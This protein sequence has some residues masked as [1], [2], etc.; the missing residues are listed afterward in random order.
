MTE[1]SVVERLQERRL[2]LLPLASRQRITERS[3][4]E[5]L[6]GV[7]AALLVFLI[8]YS[9][10]AWRLES[11]P[12]LFSDEILYTRAGIRVATAGALIWDDGDPLFVH[13]PLYFL[14]EAA[15]LR[16]TTDPS[17]V[18]RTPGDIFGWVFHAR[19]LNAIFAGLTAVLLYWLGRRLH[20][21]WL[22]ILLVAL[23]FVDPF[24]VRTNRRAMLETL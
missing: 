22:G 4:V 8:A 20:G 21:L 12:D 17:S 1:R 3:V 14:A 15:Y 16:L 24:G 2:T 9:A 10:V 5:R 18:A 13:P 7:A 23:F 19:H 6:Q 11:A